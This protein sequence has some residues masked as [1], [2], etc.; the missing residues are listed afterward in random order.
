MTAPLQTSVEGKDS[1]AKA[2]ERGERRQKLFAVLSNW[3]ARR[4][5]AERNTEVIHK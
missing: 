2:V 4:K 5:I 3:V 1:P